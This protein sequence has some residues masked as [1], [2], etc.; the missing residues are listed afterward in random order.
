MLVR[1]LVKKLAKN[2]DIGQ[3]EAVLQTRDANSPCVTIAQC[4]LKK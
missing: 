1:S 3:L 4:E 2:G